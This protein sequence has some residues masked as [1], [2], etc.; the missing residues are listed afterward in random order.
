MAWA[1]SFWFS[2]V[3]TPG[4]SRSTSESRLGWKRSIC[5]RV[6]T[7]VP[8]RASIAGSS[9]FVAV[10]ERVSRL[11]CASGGS[12]AGGAA[13]GWACA[14]AAA[15][16]SERPAASEQRHDRTMRGEAMTGSARQET[17]L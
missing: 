12:E 3:V 15:D 2:W 8:E 10:T 4:T 1:G 14:A 7:L 16:R 5:A 17:A 6:I 9:V 13:A 11:T